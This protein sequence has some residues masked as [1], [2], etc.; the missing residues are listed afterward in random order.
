MGMNVTI[1]GIDWTRLLDE[2]FSVVEE[3]VKK[4]ATLP[5]GG[6]CGFYWCYENGGRHFYA[7]DGTY[8]CTFKATRA[9]L[10]P[11]PH[12]KDALKR[13]AAKPRLG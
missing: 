9:L 6:S 5:P 2:D 1:D 10:H 8:Y 11:L 13:A 12:V 3:F 4:A 7:N